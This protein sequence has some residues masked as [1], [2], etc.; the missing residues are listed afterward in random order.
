MT[1]NASEE[2][3]LM[4]S[5]SQDP[6][7]M[8]EYAEAAPHG[9]ARPTG[10]GL[11]HDHNLEKFVARTPT[12]SVYI[13]S[14]DT[15]A[16]TLTPYKSSRSIGSPSKSEVS[17]TD[18]YAMGFASAGSAALPGRHSLHRPPADPPFS[19]S[20]PAL[21]PTGG[22]RWSWKLATLVLAGLCLVLVSLLVW[23]LT[24]RGDPIGKCPT[25]VTSGGDASRA[26]VQPP[27]NTSSP[28]AGGQPG[29][30]SAPADGPRA[31]QRRMRSLR[32][33][34]EVLHEAA[35]P[36]RSD[37]DP[38]SPAAE[39]LLEVE[40]EASGDPEP[41][42]DHQAAILGDRLI[43]F[44]NLTP[45]V[46]KVSAA[47]G[48]DEER[49]QSDAPALPQGDTP[50]P[51]EHDQAAAEAARK[52]AAEIKQQQKNAA[53]ESSWQKPTSIPSAEEPV[54]E[55]KM[56]ETVNMNPMIISGTQEQ[57]LDSESKINIL[58]GDD[59]KIPEPVGVDTDIAMDD[60]QIFSQPLETMILPIL[61]E[62][63]P[64][65]SDSQTKAGA[66][67]SS[68]GLS[69]S[70]EH[71]R[72]L[73]SHILLNSLP[74]TNSQQNPTLSP[75]EKLTTPTAKEKLPPSVPSPSRPAPLPAADPSLRP[76]HDAPWPAPR[77]DSALLYDSEVV[78]F[79]PLV[80]RATVPPRPAQPH[81]PDGAPALSDSD[82]SGLGPDAG[83]L[84]DFGSNEIPRTG[85]DDDEEK[86]AAGDDRV[87]MTTPSSR[88]ESGGGAPRRPVTVDSVPVPVAPR[89][90]TV[91]VAVDGGE[92][93]Q[94]SLVLPTDHQEV[95][96]TLQKTAPPP[97]P[98]PIRGAAETTVSPAQEDVTT[99]NT[100]TED[101]TEAQGTTEGST[102][103]SSSAPE[104]TDAMTTEEA[105]TAAVTT[106]TPET[107]PTTASP[108]AASTTAAADTITEE[109]TTAPP[110]EP[111]ATEPPTAPTEPPTEAPTELPTEAPT[112]EPSEPTQPDSPAAATTTLPPPPPRPATAAP[113]P[114]ALAPSPTCAR[115]STVTVTFPPPVPIIVVE[116]VRRKTVPPAGSTFSV[117]RLDE[118]YAETLSPHGYWSMQ[119]YLPDDAYLQWG[120]TVPRGA[121]LAVY[122]RRNALPTH[123][124]YDVHHLLRGYSR[125]L[126]R[127]SGQSVPQSFT[128]FLLQGN[129]FFSVYNDDGEE[130]P[131]TLTLT[132]AKD[133]TEGCPNGCSGTGECLLGRCECRAGFGGEDC[134]EMACP[135]LCSGNGEYRDGQCHCKPEWK[136]RECSLRHD[137]CEVPDCSGHGRCREG[138][139]RCAQGYKGEFCEQLDCPH[140]TCQGHGFC[141]EGVCVCQKGWRGA[142]CSE[143]DQDALNCLPDCSNHGQFDPDR[144]QCVCFPEWTGAVC[145]TPVCSLDCGP[146][147]FCERNQCQCE[148]GWTGPHCQSRT[149][150]PRC[151]E[152]GQCKNGTCLC[153]T[154]WNGR[155]CTLQGCPKSCSSRGSCQLSFDNEWECSCDSGWFGDDCSLPLE[156][157]CGDRVDNDKDKLVDCEDPECCQSPACA[158]SQLCLSAPDPVEI[159][160]GKH[161]PRITASFFERSQFL[162]EEDSVQRYARAEVY[163]QS[164]AAVLRGRVTTEAGYGVPGVRVSS[165]NAAEGFTLTRAD[166]W[167]DF[168]ANGGGA[169]KLWFRR[170]PFAP[171][172]RV[173]H[174]PWNEIV[175]IDDVQL[176]REPAAPLYGGSQ[177]CTEHD[178]DVMR[179]VVLASW[180]H[181]FQGGCPE[182]SAVLAESQVVQE[183]LP[184][185]G[186]ELHLVYHSSRS[187][188]YQSTI[189]LQLTPELVPPALR[190]V[191]LR[192]HLQGELFKKTFEA[193]PNIKFTYSWNR[194]NVYS[195]RVYGVAT[196]V[197][198]VG[199][200]Y[201]DCSQIIWD[202]QTTAIAGSDISISEI[203]GWNL[204]IHHAY[205]IPEGILQK[206]DGTNIHLRQRPQV[207][208]TTVGGSH[209]RPIA[210]T[211]CQGP[212]GRQRLLAATALA[213]APDGSLYVGDFNLIRRVTPA[214]EVETVAQLN[215]TGVSYRYH[216]AVSP[217]DG[218]LYVSD[219]EAYQ[220]LR[221]RRLRRPEQ[222]SQNLEAVVGSGERCPPGDEFNCGDGGRARHARLTYPKGIVVGADGSL[223]FADGTN[224][225][226]VDPYNI[227]TTLVGNNLHKS[228]WRPFPCVGTLSREHVQLRWPT[229]LA[230]SPLDGSLHFIDD[231]MVFQ[232]TSDYRVRLVAGKPLQCTSRWQ[233]TPP[234]QAAQTTLVSPQS[235][236]FSPDGDLLVAESDSQRVNRVRVIGTDG[237]IQ[238]LAGAEPKCNCREDHC[239]CFDDEHVLASEALLGG[240]SALAVTPDGAVHIS[241]QANYRIRTVSAPLPAADQRGSYHIHAPDAG[242][243]YIFNRFGQ[244]TE[245]RNIVTRRTVYRFTYN[246]NASN[247]R[248]SSVT[249]A[250]GNKVSFLRDYSYQ[251]TSIDN[252]LGQ[253][254]EVIMSPSSGLLQQFITPDRF[255]TSF[256]Y[257]DI[258]G[259]MGARYD[260]AGRS[261]VYDYDQ[262]GRLISHTTPTGHTVRLEFDLSKQGASVTVARDGSPA[263]TLLI[264]RSTVTM[265]N[266]TGTWVT[267]ISPGG[268][269]RHVTPWGHATVTGAVP[270][271]LLDGDGDEVEQHLQVPGS[272]RLEVV[273]GDPVNVF[274]WLY[275]T[276]KRGRGRD[277]RVTK[278][279]RNLKVNRDLQLALEYDLSTERQ[280]VRT[281]DGT[282]ILDATYD[283]M[284][285]PTAW[286]AHGFFLDVELEYDQFG[287][288]RQW[289]RGGRSES[290]AYDRVGRLT[291]I[292]RPDQSQ[293]VYQF[294][295]PTSTQPSAVV[296][297]SGGR[298]RLHL[299]AAGAVEAVTV[300]SGGRHSWAV[301]TEFGQVSV[302]YHWPGSQ[303]PYTVL[304][305]DR[306]QIA[307]RRLPDGRRT[308]YRH[309]SAGRLLETVWGTGDALRRY[310]PD[311][312]ALLAVSVQDADL[313][314]VTEFRL[315]AGLRKKED[316]RFQRGDDMHN[317]KFKYQY[318]GNARLRKISTVVGDTEL[319]P[320][321]LRYSST[322]GQLE[323]VDDLKMYYSHPNRSVIHDGDKSFSRVIMLSGFNA[324]QL[325]VLNLH[326][327]DV[328]R[329]ETEYDGA[330]R[331]RRQ[332]TTIGSNESHMSV[333]YTADG[334]VAAVAGDET[335]M[336]DYDVGGNVRSITARGAAV[337]RRY[338]EADR[339]TR[340]GDDAVEYDENGFLTSAGGRRLTYDAAGRLTHVVDAAGRQVGYLYDWQ[341]RLAARRSSDGQ[342]VQYLYADPGHPGR[343]SHAH[344]PLQGRTDAYL[345]CHRGQLVAIQT[346]GQRHYVATD[347]R[348]TPLALFNSHRSVVKEVRR[349]PWGRVIR[350]TN[351]A[352]P[353]D[354]GLFGW[355]RDPELGLLWDPAGR[356]YEP[357]LQQYLQ[358]GWEAA[359]H[360]LHEPAALHLYRFMDNDPVNGGAARRPPPTDLRAW[361]S[362]FG[363]DLDRMQGSVYAQRL[364]SQPAPELALPWL[365]AGPRLIS[366]LACMERRRRAAFSAPDRATVSGRVWPEGGGGGGWP[367]VPR[368]A[369]AGPPLGDGLLLSEEG[370]R[371]ALRQ[372]GP[373]GV[374]QDVAL[375]VLN[376]S[377]LLDVR[378]AD[379]AGRPQLH[380][381]RPEQRRQP[382]AEQLERLGRYNLSWAGDRLQLTLPAAAVHVHYGAG[383]EAAARRLRSELLAAARAEAVPARWRH[384]QRLVAARLPSAAGWTA[385]ERRQLLETGA[386]PGVTPADVHPLA[387]YPALAD[388]WSNL[389]L[390]PPGRR[391]SRKSARKRLRRRFLRRYAP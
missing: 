260:A 66:L 36:A 267:S 157:D 271:P 56:T 134:S 146:H 341:G 294:S 193:E 253:K 305:N 29:K 256:D 137:Q 319:S 184:V 13:P 42:T 258:S 18:R 72:P 374:L 372:V 218:S 62:K 284:G 155:H 381:L 126:S 243:T 73:P 324:P 323:Q 54:I 365:P 312:G 215:S 360:R 156:S 375:S 160:L 269:L 120:S 93:Y 225:R 345:Y 320:V 1:H 75:P 170:S 28:S 63:P 74:E 80:D 45:M 382:D 292:T 221:V 149:C 325:A 272:Q 350:D 6:S 43:D 24:A 163:N 71:P 349:D 4:W 205:N 293:L 118:S 96:A 377:R 123:T 187:R 368:L 95:T 195:Q 387:A 114:A 113:P 310:Q 47:N 285:R 174:V 255:N 55:K 363:Y 49:P 337:E 65:L 91:T 338:D 217:L 40:W 85:P 88:S 175:V 383:D 209:Q 330:G 380:F 202:T 364:A 194:L 190:L 333:N 5:D 316:N 192:V 132:E 362:E 51:A 297:P 289:R 245:T 154:G 283:R 19:Y 168:L 291:S 302:T 336:Y 101:T 130:T 46:S 108:T 300:P 268:Q 335:W 197:V 226:M 295:Q 69:S 97:A 39:D 246:L 311:G 386:V 250:I 121:S 171:A 367:L 390:R 161:P 347:T 11:G 143:T 128:E 351:A 150:D 162:I 176:T 133:M 122:G 206:G 79:V 309:D 182:E 38:S 102:E 142:D 304:L 173:L 354:V 169:V 135:L 321:V 239:R 196:A 81:R 236:A 366:G 307:E 138:T 12:G 20:K 212:A 385:S 34:R 340:L 2:F 33:R 216:L 265:V 148:P 370:G 158:D 10:H 83:S 352:L 222:L 214:G 203:G 144:R 127:T 286:R 117:V 369:A 208:R 32:V 136:G 282:A 99:E 344:R 275:F 331:I 357:R 119:F 389:A 343:L 59:V 247:G 37:P 183:S 224:I 188:G 249:D 159:L 287:R 70:Q 181:E 125:G 334:R 84:S 68:E 23:S 223:F 277:R 57:P 346:A 315:H 15:A 9:Y 234:E 306:M 141:V 266:G 379:A 355:V 227:I 262:Y 147:G 348:G 107:E 213:A 259:L 199:Y 384:E 296:L 52:K 361:L 254:C 204:D 31:A 186:T 145:D 172:E 279:G 103:P 16:N 22:R 131:V 358:P 112:V 166:G 61:N 165:D 301:R 278:V 391:R 116:D 53:S 339:L 64:L 78:E 326:G 230:V 332:T 288:L 353:L 261:T 356:V 35:A 198:R 90:V 185:P 89:T 180:K 220:I 252:P 241:D 371:A 26:D 299:A 111:T 50:E 104:P 376:A 314:S 14:S 67:L 44:S 92:L 189:Q 248:L 178:Y 233:R 139:C 235:L 232:L 115:P 378:P 77:R 276:E 210:C 318:D 273:A 373:A 270:Y 237:A 94:L 219:P 124:Q 244:H 58:L 274:E 290:Y 200:E 60:Q 106:S 152:H 17:K 257:L 82:V 100:E 110:A 105:S 231:H 8:Y 179:P 27:I 280:T 251:V 164:R 86:L 298:Y 151:E 303:R 191:H 48:F 7:D 328:F 238:P 313:D 3:S 41:A 240:I 207:L 388:D 25:E 327:Y 177:A 329:L 129:W 229:E 87:A 322:Q 21:L 76:Q 211:N 98:A 359:L 30:H 263:E 308:L 264:Q 242:H 167:F 342:L 201:A 281:A 140:P 109:V 228:H 153:V 317:T